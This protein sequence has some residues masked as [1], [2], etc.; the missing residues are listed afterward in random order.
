MDKLVY[1]PENNFD[2]S[3]GYYSLDMLADLL[4]RY[5]NDP[6]II[7]FIADMLEDGENDY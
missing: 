3:A 6:D 4:R 2:I 5:R 1:I 7:Y